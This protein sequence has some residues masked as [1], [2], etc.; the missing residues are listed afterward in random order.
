MGPEGVAGSVLTV[1]AV[2]CPR[3]CSQVHV[4]Q[5][6]TNKAV[7]TWTNYVNLHTN[8]ATNASEQL[9]A[10]K[11][12]TNSRD[13]SESSSEAI[14]AV[15]LGENSPS[16]TLISCFTFVAASNYIAVVKTCKDKHRSSFIS[17]EVLPPSSARAS[18]AELGPPDA[19]GPPIESHKTRAW[20]GQ[21]TFA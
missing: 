12:R 8:K 9:K 13:S 1:A 3:C 5:E 10:L 4:M 6:H 14:I 15:V 19:F 7:K 2:C 21:Q 18:R 20:K 11:P 17:A 16:S